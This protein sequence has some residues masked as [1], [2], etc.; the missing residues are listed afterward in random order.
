MAAIGRG[1]AIV[2]ENRRD[3]AESLRPRN[4]AAGVSI[5][6]AAILSCVIVLAG[7][8]AVYPSIDAAI[9]FMLYVL[10]FNFLPGM[11]VAHLVFPGLEELGCYLLYALSVGIA[12]NLL[13]FIPLWVMG[14]PQLIVVLPFAAAAAFVIPQG[15]RQFAG[16]ILGSS[17][18][19]RVMWW[20]A[21]ALLVT[22]TP[23]LSLQYF[24][25]EDPSA[26]IRFISGLRHWRSRTSRAAGRHP[27]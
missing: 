8:L 9:R 15:R 24:L 18:G 22:A 13:I 7:L 12:V 16:L 25:T 4:R 6:F 1:G 14:A 11:V 27:T 23:L 2:I 26:G 10:V 5:A 21:A 17:P 19:Q 20:A 3:S